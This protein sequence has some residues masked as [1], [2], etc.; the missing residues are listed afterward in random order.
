M[1][2][3]T[4]FLTLALILPV[5][6]FLFLKF[7]GRNKFEIP[8]Y[9]QDTIEIPRDCLVN[10]QAPYSVSDSTLIALGVDLHRACLI[11][12]KNMTG[13]NDIRLREEVQQNKLQVVNLSEVLSKEKESKMRCIF[14]LPDKFNS[15]LLDEQRRIRGYYQVDSRDET[16]RL[17]VELK[18]LFNDY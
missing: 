16:D 10:F 13:E 11:L 1:K 12:F 5:L 3:K 15:V 18:I 7:F 9:Y 6:V 8:V 14:L 2:R 17:L 4:F